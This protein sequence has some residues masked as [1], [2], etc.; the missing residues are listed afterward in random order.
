MGEIEIMQH[1]R[2]T[3]AAASLVRR[4]LNRPLTALIML[5]STLQLFAQTTA[6]ANVIVAQESAFWKAYTVGNITD[7]GTLLQPGFTNV[8]QEIWTRDQVLTFVEQFHKQCSLAPVALIDPH[9]SFLTPDIATIVY[10]A[11]EAATCGARTMSGDT[12]ISTV[13][14]RHDGHWQMHLHSEYAIPAK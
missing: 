2:I 11:K 12:N 4:L 3:L 1:L 8:E 6:T 9:V 10:H 13:W 14:V 5:F 7:L